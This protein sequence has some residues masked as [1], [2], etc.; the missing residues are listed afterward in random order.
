MGPPK[1][2]PRPPQ[3][4]LSGP[5]DTEP[6]VESIVLDR[7]DHRAPADPAA[8]R[9]RAGAGRLRTLGGPAAES[10]GPGRLPARLPVVPA[11]ASTG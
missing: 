1:R 7:A 8:G 6:Q 10:A 11:K 4:G 5:V 9:D 2:E 3:P